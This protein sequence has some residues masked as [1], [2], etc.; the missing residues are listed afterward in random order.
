VTHP[1]EVVNEGDEYD[2]RIIRIDSDKRRLGLSLKQAL[3]AEP[4]SGLDWQIAP[5]ESNGEQAD[6]TSDALEPMI[7]EAVGV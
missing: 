1:K 7:E 3:P 2:L 4:E 5:S 6:E